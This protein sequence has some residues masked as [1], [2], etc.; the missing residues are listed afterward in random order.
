MALDGLQ[1]IVDYIS[2]G[3]VANDA[4]QVSKAPDEAKPWALLLAEAVPDSTKRAGLNNLLIKSGIFKD[5]NTTDL[6]PVRMVSLYDT[7]SKV[8]NPETKFLNLLK[9]KAP[10]ITSDYQ[11]RIPEEVIGTDVLSPFNMDGSLPA[12][13]QS[14]LSSR[15]NTLTALGQQIQVSFM[16]EEIAA[17]S[18]YKR[19]EVA[20]QLQW[21][22]VRLERTMSALLLSNTEQKSEAVP[23]IPQLGGFLTRSTSNV[24][25]AGGSNLTDALIAASI[26]QLAAIYGYSALGDV[27]AFTNAAQ[28]PVIRNLMI[29]RFPGTD[30]M[31]FAEAQAKLGSL[32]AMGLEVQMMYKDNNNLTIPFIRDTQLPAGTTIFFRSSLPQLTKFKFG[33]KLGPFA[34][35][36]PI[37]TLY[38]LSIYFDLFSLCDPIVGSRASITGHA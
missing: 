2:K 28:I 16:A 31:T 38:N 6:G 34:L 36:R 32:N 18:P 9:S 4:P 11:F 24:T 30:P 12:V 25:P 5:V 7:I 37:A 21:A 14:T 1:D 19:N 10:F 23:N 35:D 27:V 29:N 26:N 20:A 17:Q 15:D 13:F 33:G 8:Y 22:N 3:N